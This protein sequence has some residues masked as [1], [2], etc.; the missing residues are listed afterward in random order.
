MCVHIRMITA[1]ATSLRRRSRPSSG[2]S[3]SSI[4]G[5]V[6]HDHHQQQQ[7][8]SAEAAAA[9]PIGCDR[10]NDQHAMEAAAPAPSPISFVDSLRRKLSMSVVAG[11]AY[12][13]ERQTAGNLTV[14]TSTVSGA[15]RSGN[16]LKKISGEWL[17]L[18]LPL[19]LPIVPSLPLPLPLLLLLPL[20]P[21]PLPL[22]LLPLPLP[23]LLSLLLLLLLP[24]LLPLPLILPLPLLLPLPLPLLLPLPTAATDT[25]TAAAI[26]TATAV[27]TA[28]AGCC[29]RGSGQLHVTL[30]GSTNTAKPCLR[31]AA[32]V[33]RFLSFCL[34]PLP[35]PG[36]WHNAARVNATDCIEPA[37]PVTCETSAARERTGTGTGTG[38]PTG[39]P[40]NRENI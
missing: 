12:D 22:L 8:V 7:A 37:I 19:I 17:P 21:L 27:A 14:T 3:G 13:V 5:C 23:L 25:A 6:R 16:S 34:E 18:P 20:L 36:P 29:L 24:L 35:P 9:F 30:C 4:A 33:E 2:V 26:A 28:T 40:R 32:W 38:C 39:K 10:H 31:F 11:A 15:V 1:I